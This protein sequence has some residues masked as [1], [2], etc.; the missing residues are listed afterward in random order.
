MLTCA[1]QA[2][3]A[4]FDRFEIRLESLDRFPARQ[5]FLVLIRKLHLELLGFRQH[6]LAH[7]FGAHLLRVR[8]HHRV[9]QHHQVLITLEHLLLELRH[10]GL[11]QRLS[12]WCRNPPLALI[13]TY[14][15]T[16]DPNAQVMQSRND[17][18]KTSVLRRAI[19]FDQL[20]HF[21]RHT[22]RAQTQPVT[23]C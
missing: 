7:T 20:N 9:L 15:S 21:E 10:F 11:H 1:F 18:L 5:R 3:I 8:L 4:L 12:V 13:K 23:H 6:P 2:A 17:M 19:V 16:T 22:G 14:T